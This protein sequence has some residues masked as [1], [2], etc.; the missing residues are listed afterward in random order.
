M[1]NHPI[2]P[3][4]SSK[5]HE[6][7]AQINRIVSL[8]IKTLIIKNLPKDAIP[9][10]KTIVLENNPNKLLSFARQKIPSLADKIC[11]E[12]QKI[13]EKLLANLRSNY[14]SRGQ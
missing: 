8:K 4:P 9:E 2:L 14:A 5:E 6:I 7:L 11:E 10:F 12:T 13:K 1:I 3:V